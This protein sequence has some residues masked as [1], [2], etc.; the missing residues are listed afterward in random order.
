MS[1]SGADCRLLFISVSIKV[2][3]ISIHVCIVSVRVSIVFI[4]V[5][6]VLIHVPIGSINVSYIMMVSFLVG[7][8]SGKLG[9]LYGDQNNLR[10][11][12]LS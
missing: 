8:C 2:L 9:A 4:C 1:V 7:T 12:S 5:P 10:S 6:T 11:C 3:V